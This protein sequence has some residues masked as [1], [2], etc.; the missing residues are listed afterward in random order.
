MFTNLLNRK[1][2]IFMWWALPPTP[3]IS[4]QPLCW[5]GVIVFLGVFLHLVGQAIRLAVWGG[6][7]MVSV[8]GFEPILP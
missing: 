7:W 8:M 6:R 3:P 5:L 1:K 4:F 2:T